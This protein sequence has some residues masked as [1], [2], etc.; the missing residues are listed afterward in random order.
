[1]KHPCSDDAARVLALLFGVWRFWRMTLCR[2]VDAGAVH[3]LIVAVVVV[4]HADAYQ[5]LHLG[6]HFEAEVAG[7]VTLQRHE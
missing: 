4:V 2:Y 3:I 6:A 1:M 7:I 5:C